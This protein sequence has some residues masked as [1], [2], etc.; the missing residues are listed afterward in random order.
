M[1]TPNFKVGDSVVCRTKDGSSVSGKVSY[2]NRSHI[3]VAWVSAPGRTQVE[4]V[5]KTE[6]A[7]R[8][9]PFG[10]ATFLTLL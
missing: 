6:A 3:Y 2:V 4:Q 7:A 10:N 5:P 9:T 8:I 1:S